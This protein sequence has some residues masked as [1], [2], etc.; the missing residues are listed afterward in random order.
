MILILLS[1]CCH[2]QNYQDGLSPF[3][4]E[5]PPEAALSALT[6]LAG[7]EEV[8]PCPGRHSLALK[9]SW[10]RVSSRSS[11][12]SSL[13]GVEDATRECNVGH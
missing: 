2:K 8:K 12:S 4:P 5:D 9:D 1:D 11:I 10:P 7:S 3:H 13:L 6:C